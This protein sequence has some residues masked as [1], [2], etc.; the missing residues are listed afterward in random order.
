GLLLRRERAAFHKDGAVWRVADGVH[1]LVEKL[2]EFGGCVEIDRLRKVVLWAVVAD[3][4]PLAV[5]LFGV[6]VGVVSEDE[7]DSRD[8]Y[9]QERIVVGA[10][11]QAALGLA[12]F[13]DVDAHRL[14]DFARGQA[15][16][17]IVDGECG[18]DL[19]WEE[20]P[21]LVEID[22]GD[23]GLFGYGWIVDEPV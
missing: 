9:A 22:I 8:A 18:E 19:E 10:A 20:R 3:L 5:T 14:A 6:G 23:E 13:A 11:Q 17:R 1:Q 2:V 21:K 7:A 15:E 4:V 16:G 12:V